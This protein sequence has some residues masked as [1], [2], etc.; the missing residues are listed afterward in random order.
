[1]CVVDQDLCIGCGLCESVCS[2]VFELND[3]KSHIKDAHKASELDCTDEAAE[4]CP[5]AATVVVE[6]MGSDLFFDC[7][8]HAFEYLFPQPLVSANSPL[9]LEVFKTFMKHS[10]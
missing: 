3:R 5:M 6:Q 7:V 9:G 2:E 10:S 1:M 8:N 4:S